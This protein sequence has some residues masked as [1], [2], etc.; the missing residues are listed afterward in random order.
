MHLY[1]VEKKNGATSDG[2]VTGETRMALFWMGSVTGET[3]MALFRIGGSE[4]AT[5][6]EERPSLSHESDCSPTALIKRRICQREA[7]R[8]GRAGKSLA[9]PTAAAVM[10]GQEMDRPS[11]P[12]ASAPAP[13]PGCAEP[14]GTA[15]RAFLP[16]QCHTSPALAHSHQPPPQRAGTPHQHHAACCL[17]KA[18]AARYS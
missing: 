9:V 8:R 16:P 4:Q 14:G 13:L 11:R 10:N 3:R 17:T 2:S 18:N 7:G 15:R 1:Q 5:A 6:G 12:G